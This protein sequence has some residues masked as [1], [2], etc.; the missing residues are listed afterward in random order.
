LVKLPPGILRNG[1]DYQWTVD[2]GQEL[3]K[4]YAYFR[5][6]DEASSVELAK[7]ISQLKKY[8][9]DVSMQLSYIFF[10]Q[11]NGLY[12]LAENEIANLKGKQEWN[13]F[14]IEVLEK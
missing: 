11:E 7:R 9:S 8:G 3:G 6:L 10:L 14:M 4:S 12:S 13:E 1:A 2:G 5:V